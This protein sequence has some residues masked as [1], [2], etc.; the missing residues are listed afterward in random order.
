MLQIRNQSLLRIMLVGVSGGEST[1]AGVVVAD[2]LPHALDLGDLSL[3][4]A[5]VSVCSRDRG[6]GRRQGP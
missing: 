3:W 1:T 6:G 2:Y 4:K 5:A